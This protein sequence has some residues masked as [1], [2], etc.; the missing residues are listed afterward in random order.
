MSIDAEKFLADHYK[1]LGDFR[2]DF[3]NYNL[4]ILVAKF[5]NGEKVLDIGSGAGFLLNEIEK[6]GKKVYGIEPNEELVKLT[7]A[8]FSDLKVYE[9]MAEDLPNL[10]IP[11]VDTILMI[12]VLEHVEDDKLQVKKVFSKLKSGGEFV[13]IVPAYQALYGIRDENQGHFRRYSMKVLIDLLKDAGFE[14]KK[15]RYWNILGVL[16]YIISEKIFKRPLE[17][18][19]RTSKRR[20]FM[21]KLFDFWFRNIEN[22]INFGVGLSIVVV[23]KKPS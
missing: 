22:K 4:A 5:I 16:P 17:S 15:R 20:G 12:D 18:K 2:N 7:N 9:G 11:V 6:K 21:S 23:A 3:R 10:D 8:S 19:I 13:V 14:I 1:A